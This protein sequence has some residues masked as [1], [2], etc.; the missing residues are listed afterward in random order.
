MSRLRVRLTLNR[1]TWKNALEYADATHRSPSELVEEAIDQIMARYPKRPRSDATD[2]DALAAKV[3]KILSAKISDEKE[4]NTGAVPQVQSER[5]PL[6][7]TTRVRAC[8]RPRQHREPH[9]TVTRADDRSPPP[10][11]I[12]EGESKKHVP[13]CYYCGLPASGIDH[14]IPRSVLRAMA[15]VEQEAGRARRKLT[16]SCC[17]ECNSL[18]GPTMQD[19]LAERKLFLKDR[20]RKKYHALLS[21]PNWNDSELS[22]MGRHLRN[23]ILDGLGKR[24]TLKDRLAW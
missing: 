1:A 19:T 3:A 18:L 2:L 20:L 14:V 23:S 9:T 5:R 11:R 13:A 7:R 15:D 4:K 17:A 10:D 12:P 24:K 6:P 22:K 16:V 8:E 21:I